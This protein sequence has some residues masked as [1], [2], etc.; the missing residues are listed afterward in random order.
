MDN[1][2]YTGTIQT[3]WQ[4]TPYQSQWQGIGDLD[5]LNSNRNFGKN[6]TGHPTC[7]TNLWVE[8]DPLKTLAPPVMESAYF[9]DARLNIRISLPITNGRAE[10]VAFL[11][12]ASLNQSNPFCTYPISSFIYKEIIGCKDVFHFD[13]PWELAK[14][15]KWNI[16]N[17]ETHQVWKG[18]VI[19]Q[20]QEWLENVK[21]W[22]FVQSVLRIKLRFQ[23]FVSASLVNGT[24]IYNQPDVT[25]A[26]TKQL[27]PVN[28]NDKP[29]IELV[30]VLPWPY[31]LSSSFSLSNAPTG[32]IQSVD[33]SNVECT[34]FALGGT[35]KQR[36][37]TLLTLSPKTC[38]LD[39]NYQLKWNK[40]CDSTLAANL[41]P[42]QPADILTTVSYTLTSENFCAEVQVDVGIY[43][44]LTVYQDAA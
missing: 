39:G 43:G 19:L 7:P 44:T 3:P 37:T 40:I 26:I 12:D 18:Q 38:T 29:T 28:I 2:V 8:S 20:F 33:Y 10:I 36:W 4:D 9:Q 11:N 6:W 14:T 5:A 41:C 42:L 24:T 27:V 23:R 35:C 13:I 32:K 34:G 21:E 17:E 15:C 1:A 31:R 30:S 25:A 16:S 22:R